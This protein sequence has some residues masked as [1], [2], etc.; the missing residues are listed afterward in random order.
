[1]ADSPRPLSPG[2]ALALFIVMCVIWG[3]TW[4]AIRIG[5]DVLPPLFFAACRFLVAGPLLLGMTWMSGHRLTVPGRGFQ[6]LATAM[7]VNTACY[8]PIFWGMRHVPTGFSAV[9]NLSLIPVGVFVIGIAAGQERFVWA[10]LG[11]V[12]LGVAGL[13]IMFEGRAAIDP[14]PEALAGAAA[15]VAGTV[16]FCLGSVLT[17]PLARD[18]PAFFIGGWHCVL[19]GIGLAILSFVI[20]EPSPVLFV[21]FADPSVL[22]GWAFL[23]FGGS[24]VASS[25]YLRLLHTWGPTAAAGYS[26]VSPAI[27]A[28]VGALVFAER[29]TATEGVG[30]LVM[31]AATFLMLRTTG[32]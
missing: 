7:L 6:L 5:I 19:G 28:A 8:G 15:I 23:V 21:A 25:I 22:A 32:R 27:A 16:S 24:I 17:R 10:R 20:E 31:F 11:A 1:M 4:I 26:F 12:I 29:Y 13:A 18:L 3:L 30:A 2:W 14:S 9:I